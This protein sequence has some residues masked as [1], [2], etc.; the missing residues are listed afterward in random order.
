MWI[1]D[2]L[3]ALLI[4]LYGIA[5]FLLPVWLIKIMIWSIFGL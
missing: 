3:E 1:T 5:V 2:F 4:V